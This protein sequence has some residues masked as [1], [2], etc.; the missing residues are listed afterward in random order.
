M[1]NCWM[2]KMKTQMKKTDLIQKLKQ[3]QGISDDERAY[4][5]NLVNTKE[6]WSGVGRKARRCG[7]TA[8]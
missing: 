1:L 2:T 8:A 7:R 6:V 4:L 5:I 3:L